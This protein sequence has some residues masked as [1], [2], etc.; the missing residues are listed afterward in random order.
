MVVVVWLAAPASPPLTDFN[1]IKTLEWPSQSADLNPTEM[2]WDDLKKAVW[3]TLQCGWFTTTTW[4]KFLHKTVK[5]S[6][7]L[8]QWWKPREAQPVIRGQPHF[9]TGPAQVW[10]FFLFLLI[11]KQ[12]N[13]NTALCLSTLFYLS[14]L[15]DLTC[16]KLRK[17]VNTFTHQENQRYC[18]YI[19]TQ[20]SMWGNINKVKFPCREIE[21][22]CFLSIESSRLMIQTF[23]CEKG[24]I[25]QK[26]SYFFELFSSTL[27]GFH[28]ILIAAV[29]IIII[30]TIKEMNKNSG[31]T[32]MLSPHKQ[33]L[34]CVG[35]RERLKIKENQESKWL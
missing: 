16:L 19:Q 13:L 27:L 12:L 14:N 28:I 33:A 3:K 21:P 10:I 9:H 22:K 26:A 23:M 15:F 31:E 34:F 30:I 18:V 6:Q 4:P 7:T 29:V 8:L 1:K 35:H 11:I 17:G 25:N 5:L 2:L 32:R 24:N 20:N